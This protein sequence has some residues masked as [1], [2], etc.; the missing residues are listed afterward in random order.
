MEVLSNRSEP[1]VAD[2][3]TLVRTRL[4]DLRNSSVEE[5]D[6]VAE[7]CVQQAVEEFSSAAGHIPSKII[8]ASV[9]RPSFYV[10]RFLPL[11]LSPSAKKKES[12]PRHALV[13]ELY[14]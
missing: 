1:F 9:F 14:K 2:Y 10:R 13:M 3:I 7:A 12:G 8:E 6:Y 11:L 5:K 4:I